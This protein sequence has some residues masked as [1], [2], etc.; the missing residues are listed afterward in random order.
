MNKLTEVHVNDCQTTK[1]KDFLKSSN[2]MEEYKLTINEIIDKYVDDKN[3]IDDLEECQY[4]MEKYDI[5]TT[6]KVNDILER[7]GE[8][9]TECD[10]ERK[11]VY[12]LEEIYRSLV[13]TMDECESNWGDNTED[14]CLYMEYMDSVQSV[15]DFLSEYEELFIKHSVQY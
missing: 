11:E 1:G 7:Y 14:D 8:L 2:E 6:I 9:I 5:D 4:L 3:F 13:D 15:E 10:N 12:F